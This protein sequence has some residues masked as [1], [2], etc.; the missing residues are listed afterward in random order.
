M[1]TPFRT[2]L[3]AVF[4]G[5]FAT[6]AQVDINAKYDI[7]GVSFDTPTITSNLAK[8]GAPSGTEMLP[9]KKGAADDRSVWE[10]FA[11]DK[12]PCPAEE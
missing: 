2:I 11:Q 10:K 6:L 4:D 12:W 9:F 8:H 5:T 7:I 3:R 1:W